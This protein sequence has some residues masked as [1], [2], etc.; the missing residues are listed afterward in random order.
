MPEIGEKTKVATRGAHEEPDWIVG[1][2]RDAEGIDRHFAQF[3]AVAGAK[4]P[5]IE[6]DFQL[7]F[8][9]VA[10]KPIAINGD[11]QFRG[12]ADQPADMVGMLMSDQN[13]SELFRSASDAQQPR[14]NL[15]SA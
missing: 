3:E 6:P 14:A 2:V 9:G 8:D 1:V 11:L 5:E 12:Q 10:G 15:P 13:A 4:K 7:A